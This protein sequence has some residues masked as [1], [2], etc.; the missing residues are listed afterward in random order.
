VQVLGRNSV[1]VAFGQ[2]PESVGA[3]R[4]ASTGPLLGVPYEFVDEVDYERMADLLDQY[5]D[6]RLARR[7]PLG[8]PSP[9]GSISPRSPLSAGATSEWFDRGMCAP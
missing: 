8:S 4:S 2:T 9:T 1:T 7:T 3:Q 6:C 5:A